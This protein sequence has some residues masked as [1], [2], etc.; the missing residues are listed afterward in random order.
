[1]TEKGNTNK[2]RRCIFDTPHIIN[3]SVF[4]QRNIR[5]FASYSNI[6]NDTSNR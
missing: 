3:T 2:I 4:V 1:M 6:K 5:N